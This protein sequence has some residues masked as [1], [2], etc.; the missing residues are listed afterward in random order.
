M[1]PQGW[2]ASGDTHTCRYNQGSGLFSERSEWIRA[3]QGG[4][5]WIG[6]DQ[7]WFGMVVSLSDL[8]SHW[9]VQTLIT[10]RLQ[11]F[12]IHFTV[13]NDE[14]E[15]IKMFELPTNSNLFELVK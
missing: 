1:A 5:P 12:R 9:S 8:A 4:S 2:L 10:P 6:S 3:D 14:L 13:S 15:N 7:V 11:E